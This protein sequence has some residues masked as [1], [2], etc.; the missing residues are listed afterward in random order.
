MSH[1]KAGDAFSDFVG[2]LGCPSELI[3]ENIE[4]L[5]K[6]NIVFIAGGCRYSTS[7]SSGK[8]AL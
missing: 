7:I 8:M 5:K 3:H 2:P 1:L 4:D 6:Q